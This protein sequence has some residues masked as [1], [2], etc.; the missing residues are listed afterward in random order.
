MDLNVPIRV[1]YEGKFTE[2][3]GSSMYIGGF[4]RT[5]SIDHICPQII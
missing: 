2:S 1:W 5:F 4:G 3:K